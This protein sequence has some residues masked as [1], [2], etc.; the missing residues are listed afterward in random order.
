VWATLCMTSTASGPRITFCEASEKLLSV[1]V[2]ASTSRTEIPIA[3]RHDSEFFLALF[4][5]NLR[6]DRL[7]LR[8]QQSNHSLW[9][10]RMVGSQGAGPRNQ[11]SGQRGGSPQFDGN[12]SSVNYSSSL[13]IHGIPAL[14]LHTMMHVVNDEFV[15]FLLR[16]MFHLVGRRPDQ[17]NEW[18]LIRP[19]RG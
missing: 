1:S 2:L 10:P 4:H 8:N 5:R 19:H 6:A 7:P 12:V 3:S 9:R 18:V 13:I 11:A 15:V 17:H 14:Q 16:R